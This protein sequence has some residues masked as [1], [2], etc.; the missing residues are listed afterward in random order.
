M[1]LLL[2]TKLWSGI[3]PF[4]LEGDERFHGLPSFSLPFFKMLEDADFEKIHVLLFVQLNSKQK[5]IELKL[6]ERY[7]E[8]LVVYPIYY[9]RYRD[10]VFKLP[11]AVAKAGSI[12]RKRKIS[13]VIGH[14]M[15]S[16]VAGL[17]SLLFGVKN[18]RRIY[19]IGTELSR[20][21]RLKLMFFHPLEYLAFTLPCEAL[22]VTNDGSRGDELFKK[23]NG[24]RK[25][26]RN[27]IF[28]LNGVFKDIESRIVKPQNV[29]ELPERYIAYIGRFEKFK[30]QLRMV[31]ALSIL[32]RRAQKIP[33]VMVGQIFDPAYYR[34]LMTKIDEL[35]LSEYVKIIPGLSWSETMYVLANSTLAC[36]F[37]DLNLSNVFLEGLSL[38]VPM[39]SIN[40][41]NSLEMIPDNVFVKLPESALENPEIIADAIQRLWEDE[42]QRGRLSQAA[43]H[44][45][46]YNLK[47]WEERVNFEITLIKKLHSS[48]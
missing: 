23:L 15:V 48:E 14:G 16:T 33:V 12:V 22:I 42:Q 5:K 21:S 47:D 44:F 40:S 26:I 45:A 38:G 7:R 17:V 39:I 37:Y 20:K 18:I 11:F 32:H 46:R 9:R 35:G 24:R 41:G 3:K 34:I 25:K 2:I 36:A 29:G 10:L 27:F 30:G 1:E 43:K 4:F 13:V 6:P 28:E 31:D 8:R 19:G